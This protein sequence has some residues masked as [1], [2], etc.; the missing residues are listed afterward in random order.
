MSL[1]D[2]C[3]IKRVGPLYRFKG[4][5]AAVISENYTAV[6]ALF[7]DPMRPYGNERF[8]H[9]DLADVS[10]YIKRFE[11]PHVA[12]A[13]GGLYDL[14]LLKKLRS[15]LDILHKTSQAISHPTSEVY[16]ERVFKKTQAYTRQF[17]IN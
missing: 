7:E 15:A 8:H 13:I 9:L 1:E 6:V 17:T 16:A 11:N 2:I 3:E 4:L 5:R 12:T 10:H 14:N